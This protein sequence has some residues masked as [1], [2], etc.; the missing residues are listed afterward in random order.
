[1][2]G[3]PD[4]NKPAGKRSGQGGRP[5]VG[6]G[7][8]A[9]GRDRPTPG[10]PRG[11]HGHEARGVAAAPVSAGNATARALCKGSSPVLSISRQ[12]PRNPNV[13]PPGEA[14]GALDFAL[15]RK[16]LKSQMRREPLGDFAGAAKKVSGGV[17]PRSPR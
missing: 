6:A 11:G 4:G 9:A 2:C 10:A 14:A 17:L 13:P 3:H 12:R 15:G 8:G 1:M 5:P 7:A 16:R